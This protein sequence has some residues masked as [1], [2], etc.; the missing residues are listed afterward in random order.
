MTVT[1]L[2]AASIHVAGQ[3]RAFLLEVEGFLHEIGS[4][5]DERAEDLV[6]ALQLTFAD[7]PQPGS[8]RQLERLATALLGVLREDDQQ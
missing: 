8:V 1:A 2:E 5:H 3:T 7:P 6:A 4:L